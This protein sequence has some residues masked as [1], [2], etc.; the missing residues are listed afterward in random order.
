[1][2]SH[3]AAVHFTSPL[4][5]MTLYGT[6]YAL[7]RLSFSKQPL[8]DTPPFPLL[9]K[10]KQHIFEYL[11]GQRLSLHLPLAP[12]GTPFQQRVW[13]ALLAIPY[14][15]T[16]SYKDIATIIGNPRA[17]RAVGMANNK[18]PLPILIPCH[19][20]IGASGKLTGYAGSLQIKHMLLMLESK[21]QHSLTTSP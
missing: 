19:R 7:T 10:G 15:E 5:E 4:G 11:N 17:A 3:I 1:M 13:K 2:S 9:S 20:V 14:G 16:R 12:E 21:S 6:E 8:P 18:N